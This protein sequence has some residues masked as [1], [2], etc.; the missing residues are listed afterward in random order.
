MRH[1]RASRTATLAQVERVRDLR[2]VGRHGRC[3]DAAPVV[4]EPARRSPLAS[5]QPQVA[6]GGHHQRPAVRRPGERAA[7][8][9]PAAAWHEV[10]GEGDR[11]AAVGRHDDE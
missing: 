2:A 11:R 10:R 8:V 5:H 4:G 6:G 7:A 9:A 1:R 3:A